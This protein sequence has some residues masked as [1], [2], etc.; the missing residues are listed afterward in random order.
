MTVE[1]RP[2]RP[3]YW[4]IAYGAT[5]ALVV[6][7]VGVSTVGFTRYI[8]A[9]DHRLEQQAKLD[10][11]ASTVAAEFAA[12]GVAGVKAHDELARLVVLSAGGTDEFGIASGAEIVLERGSDPSARPRGDGYKQELFNRSG[13]LQTLFER[14]A[15]VPSAIRYSKDELGDDA[16]TVLFGAFAPVV[17][18]GTYVGMT[19]VWKRVTPP[20]SSV[21][22]W[23]LLIALI[24]SFALGFFA[25]R[26]PAIGKLSGERVAIAAAATV[27]MLALLLGQDAMLTLVP[28]ALALVMGLLGGPGMAAVFRGLREQPSAYLYVTPAMIGM[29]VLVFIPFIMGVALSFTSG[30]KFAGF[31][32]F[33]EILFPP[34]EQHPTF[35]WTFGFTVLWTVTNVVLHVGIGLTLALILNRENLR[36]KGLYRVLLVVPWAVPNYITALIWKSLF[37]SQSGAVNA[38]LDVFGIEPVNWLGPGSGFWSNFMAALTTNV[39]LGF[40]FMMVVTLGALQSIPKDLYEAADIDGAGRWQKFRQVTLPLLKPALIPAVI[41]GVIW[42]FNMFNVI[43]LVSGGGPEGET[44]ILITEAYHAFKELHREGLAAAYALLIFF[45]LLAYGWM[46]NRITKATKG[47]FE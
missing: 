13:T 9:R 1:A 2:S 30:D 26:V 4:K 23:R 31:D 6:A 21:P 34:P 43:Y 41:L 16:E 42:T 17:K 25:E 46:Q 44:N 10:A 5:A 7:I 15:E 27:A 32:N 20:V 35:Y 37:S 18:D 45:I 28:T 8:D 11:A 3:L 38:L 36:F 40:P 39:W 19:G 33:K 12:G 24:L 29:V 47:A 22:T 14:K